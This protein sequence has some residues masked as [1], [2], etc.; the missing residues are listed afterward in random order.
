MSMEMGVLRPSGEAH[1]EKDDFRTKDGEP[2]ESWLQDRYGETEAKKIREQTQENC[3]NY[4]RDLPDY[5]GSE[6][7][8]IPF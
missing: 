1:D 2:V 4:L 7:Q 8:R 3:R 5:G 6:S